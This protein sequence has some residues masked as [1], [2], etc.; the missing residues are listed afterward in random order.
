MTIDTKQLDK[1]IVSGSLEKK[2]VM[3]RIQDWFT[4]NRFCRMK[5]IL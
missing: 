1:R 5:H 3:T 2:V 4:K